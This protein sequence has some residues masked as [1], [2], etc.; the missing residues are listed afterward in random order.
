MDIFNVESIK[1][2]IN[3]LNIMAALL[4]EQEIEDEEDEEDA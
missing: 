3:G 1:E 4:L 2:Y